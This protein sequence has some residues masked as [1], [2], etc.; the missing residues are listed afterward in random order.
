MGNRPAQFGG[1]TIVRRR[2]ADGVD[3]RNHTRIQ[4]GQDGFFGPIY[5]SGPSPPFQTLL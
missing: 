4:S 1:I 5:T 2:A 3:W